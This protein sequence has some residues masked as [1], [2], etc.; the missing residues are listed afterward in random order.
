MEH[1]S[2]GFHHV[3]IVAVAMMT[4]MV[5]SS[6]VEVDSQAASVRLALLLAT[7]YQAATKAAIS[8]SCGILPERRPGQEPRIPGRGPLVQLRLP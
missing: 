4:V 2:D 6:T 3:A 7:L 5:S 1:R 8:H